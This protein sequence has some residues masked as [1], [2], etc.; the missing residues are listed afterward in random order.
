[1]NMGPVLNKSLIPPS[2]VQGTFQKRQQDMK[3]IPELRNQGCENV[4][5][6]CLDDGVTYNGC[7]TDLLQRERMSIEDKPCGLHLLHGKNLFLEERKGRTVKIHNID[8]SVDNRKQQRDRE[9]Y[10]D[11]KS[12]ATQ[13]VSEPSPS[14][15]ARPEYHNVEEP[16]ENNLKN[17]FMRMLEAFIKERKNSLKEI[18]NKTNKTLEEINKSL[19]Q[20]QEKHEKAVKQVKETVQDLK[21]EI[22]TMKKTQTEEI[23]EIENLSKQTGM[24]A[25]SITT[26][27][28]EK[29]ERVS[30]IED[31]IE[32]IDSSVKE[33]TKA[34]NVITQNVQEMWDTMKRPNL[35]IMG[36]EGEEYQLKGTENIFNKIIEENFPNLKK[37]IPMKVQ[38]AYRTPNRL[39]PP[40]KFP[41]HIKIKPLNIQNKE[42]IKSSKGK[43]STDL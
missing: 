1:M 13:D 39:D 38:K 8:Y 17:N 31:T 12:S 20:S 32:E 34:N 5:A 23:L 11:P 9:W 24:S 10:N 21:S 40:N 27:I 3:T 18:E 28:E 19:K 22:E 26:R 33:N 2:D 37:E 15:T 35:K 42:N 7:R 43:R 29:E 25:S 30:H 36:I 4:D 16:E 6:D 14:T 41:H